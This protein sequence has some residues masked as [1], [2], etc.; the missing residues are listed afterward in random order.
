MFAS[1]AVYGVQL[2]DN[3]SVIHMLHYIYVL[4]HVPMQSVSHCFCLESV[5]VNGSNQKFILLDNEKYKIILVNW[6]TCAFV[7]VRV[8]H[9]TL[10]HYVNVVHICKQII[11]AVPPINGSKTFYIVTSRHWIKANIWF[12]IRYATSII[13]HPRQRCMTLY[14]SILHVITLTAIIT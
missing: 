12:M 8:I 14:Q 13:K 7:I 3:P 11:V 6:M 1:V 4:P 5:W 2:I 10:Y 9:V